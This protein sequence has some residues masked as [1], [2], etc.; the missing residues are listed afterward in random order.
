MK[1]KTQSKTRPPTTHRGATNPRAEE[2][3]L[4]K[5]SFTGLQET[6]WRLSRDIIEMTT[7]AGSGHPS[8]SLSAI[9]I[10]T[11][12]YFGGIL[13]YTPAQPDWPGRDRFILSKGHGAPALYAVLAEAGYFDKALLATLRQIGSP[14]EGHPNMR[15]LP[16]V[17]ASTGSLGQGLSIG[18][19]HAL[20]ARVDGRDYRVY[21][22][23]G[24]GEADE[25][26]NWEAAMCAAKYKMDNLTLILDYNG[27][28][29]TAAVDI[30]MPSLAPVVAKWQAFGWYAMSIDGHNMEQIMQALQT[31]PTITQQPQIIIAHTRKGRGLSPFEKNDTNRK[32]GEALN[33]AEMATALAELDEMKYWKGFGDITPIITPQDKYGERTNGNR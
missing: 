21:V 6:A 30:V 33:E 1:A 5:R 13:R 7:K 20:A 15:A 28:Q 3:V 26:Q 27:F 24:D 32:H 29:Q 4:H 19:G 12:L 11:G 10:L 17:E 14:V 8:S 18:L 23:M 22:L 2:Q 31:L 16:G 9:D 25:G